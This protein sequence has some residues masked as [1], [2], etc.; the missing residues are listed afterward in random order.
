MGLAPPQRPAPPSGAEERT[1]LARLRA[2]DRAAF[3]QLVG[4]HGGAMLRVAMSFLRERA[5]AEEVVQDAWLALLD[6]L[7]GFEERA[8]LRTW[9]FSIL[10][11]KARTRA[12]REG[13][14]LPFSALADSGEAQGWEAAAGGF[15]QAGRWREP[16]GTWSEENPE[17]LAMGAET[18]ALL[19]AEI[20]RLPDAQRT[21]LTL[22][23]VEGLE[24]EEVCT[25]LGI[26]AANQRVLLH[27]ARS[28]VRQ[29]LQGYLAGSR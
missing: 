3:A 17:R 1:I 6:G 8:S 10:V 23:D 21:V 22:R 5:K 14:T 13:R 4:L 27:R 29:A 2:G 16:P 24:A 28:K 19:E 7:D 12:V 9:L 25:L 20:A 11:N 26:S 15:D 18:R